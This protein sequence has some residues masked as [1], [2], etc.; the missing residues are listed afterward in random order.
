MSTDELDVL[1]IEDNP[2][3]ARLIEEMLG[4]AGELLQ[5]VDAG[6]SVA[7]GAT[8]HHE[9]RLSSGLDRLADLDVD[10]V[11]LDLDLPDSTGL[12][13]LAAVID[14]TTFVPVVVLTGLN[15]GQVGIEAIQH[16]AQDYLVK[17]EVASDLL[18]R[19]IHHAIERNHQEREQVRRREQ[20]EAL[21]TLTRDL[22]DAQT[23]TEVSEYVIDAAEEF[24]GLHVA[25]IALYEGES[26]VLEP[27]RATEAAA[28]LLEESGILSRG[29]GA[30]WQSFVRNE[31]RRLTPPDA[32]PTD[33]A[34]SELAILPLTRHGVFVVGATEPTGFSTTN[35]EF[36]ETVAG[37]LEA[38][39]DRVDR[40]RQL[41]EREQTLQEQTQTLERLNRVNDIIRNI[42]Q[43]LVQ[44]STR[45]E[46]ETVVCEQLTDAGP[47]ELAWIGEHDTVAEELVPRTS[48]GSG[49][50]YV[51]DISISTSE[52]AEAA[53]PARRAVLSREPQVVN[54]ILEHRSYE[55]WR[56]DALN[57]GYHASISLPLIYE[58]TLYG[59]LNVYAGQPDVFDE[60]EQ[61][62]L[63]ELADTI[64]YAI[65][66]VERKKALLS[67]RVRRLTFDVTNSNMTLVQLAKKLD[68]E[69]VLENVVSR[70]DGGVRSFFSTRG[71]SP[72]QATEFTPTIPASKVTLVSDHVA[73]DEQVC[74]FEADLTS[75]SLAA[76]ALDHGGRLQTYQMVDGKGTVVVE[77]AADGAVREFVEMLKTQYPGSE[78]V[79][80]RT[81]EQPQ[82]SPL[83]L[84]GRMI[85]TLT[86][87]QLE[88]L[89]IAYFSGYFEEPRTRTASE[90]AE[91]MGISQ[92]TFNSH[93]RA[94]QQKIFQ[95]LLDDESV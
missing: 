29:E 37:N 5:R 65:N 52:D 93:L 75:E 2:G 30:G 70:P 44:A 51:D 54:S 67:S 26:G 73:D 24:L 6:Q 46:I 80:Q 18:V 86:D 48:A 58:D 53:G 90:I 63:A 61:A 59:I 15:T 7:S 23:A 10:V 95:Q 55:S 43:A 49:Q 34:V 36:A 13:T 8:V 41:Q 47:Y 60:L 14:E 78:L 9:R 71:V 21:N 28:E 56:Q 19:T 94:A 11:L 62:V 4:D 81:H 64:A 22:M 33:T 74:L 40:E 72:E 35:F 87:R 77:M 50:S 82:R 20:L 31:S 16:G 39:F 66:S 68:A 12:D 38:A 83:E 88:A 57:Y 85:E 25:A 69:F 3:D 92:P 79:A 42:A 17:D 1:L 89:Q 76:T 84:R 91:T 32:E 27:T 45:A